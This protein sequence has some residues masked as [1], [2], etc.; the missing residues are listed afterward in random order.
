MTK[1]ILTAL[2]IIFTHTLW[3]QPITLINKT[4]SDQNCKTL[5]IGIENVLLINQNNSIRI[6]PQS[7][8][9]LEQNKLTI[10][11][12]SAGQLTVV[13]LTDSGEIPITFDVKRIPDLIPVISG[14]FNGK[15][16]K[17]VLLIEKSISLKTTNNDS[18]FVNFDVVS[19]TVKFDSKTY[20]IKG[21]RFSDEILNELNSTKPGDT[22]F[23]SSIVGHNNDVDKTINISSNYFFN[24][25]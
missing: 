11:P 3:G 9:E 10:K 12:R 16:N 6:E 13:F 21:N 18:F 25:N 23:I 24:I 7:G 4:V 5:Y 15:I 14:Q 22:I 20:D 19:F 1:N 8:V 17:D 2:F